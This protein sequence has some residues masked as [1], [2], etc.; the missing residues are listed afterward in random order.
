MARFTTAGGEGSGA[1]GPAGADGDSAYDIAVANGF[2]GTEQEWLDSLVSLGLDISSVTGD[3][4]P[5]ADNTYVL[6]NSSYRWRS[7]SVGDG[8][9]YI[10][11]A[12]TGAEA[13][14]T[15]EDGVFFIDGIAQ[16]QLPNLAVTNLTFAD[17]TV[18]TT[19]YTG[20]GGSADL[21][22][23]VFTAGTAT[24]N[25]NEI[26]SIQSNNTTQ[27][28]SQLVLN[29]TLG[30]AKLQAFGTADTT[31]FLAS[32]PDWDSSAW[33]QDSSTMSAINFVNAPNIINFFTTTPN[34]VNDMSIVIN[35]TIV[36]SY[37]GASY[38]A[39]DILIYVENAL[40]TED[41][42]VNSFSFVFTPT[43]YI[44]IDEDDAL[45]NIRASEN[46]DVRIY[47]GDDVLI[48]A[49]GDDI[50][51]EASDDIRFTS[52]T[53][54]DGDEQF[55]RMN[56]EGSFTLPGDG[57]I[58]N[59]YGSGILTIDGGGSGEF[60]ND[61]TI[62]G[63]QI[64]TISDIANEIPVEIDFTVNG[65]TLGTQPTFD[66]SPLFS[67]TYAKTGPLVHFQIQVDMDNIT[68]F[69][70]GQYY[71]DLPFPAKYGYKFREGCLHDISTGRDYE[72]GGHVLAGQSR[73]NLTS[74]DASGNSVFD[75]PFVYNNPITL[76]AEDNFHISGTYIIN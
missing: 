44:N 53:S 14:L 18:Q 34:N 4:L 22:D 42:T 48:T 47:G 74:T 40:P 7:I 8:T 49:G 52:N 76:N 75:I 67:G 25:E 38:G 39:T 13:A 57:Y 10:T 60:L 61:A 2:V 36:G 11:D 35:D 20:G 17:S 37:A 5:S 27:L 70:T 73:L 26:L 59:P 55:W 16:A 46:M 33:T 29:P 66:G 63:N 24:V 9:I 51:L 69:G 19:A 54:G 65:G 3:I 15:I 41:P 43:S 23:F 1:P 30:S 68:S 71:V 32:S 56:S 45:L 72:I 6:G 28:K 50:T 31:T 21:G 12:V 64:A 62:P 58:S